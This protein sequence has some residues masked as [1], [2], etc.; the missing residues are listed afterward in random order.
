MVSTN[1]YEC[2]LTQFL[3]A[4][5]NPVDMK[6]SFIERNITKEIKNH[7]E[8]IV[9]GSGDEKMEPIVL[10]GM[11]GSGKSCSA[12][13]CLESLELS[14]FVIEAGK[15][16][17][18]RKSLKKLADD[19]SLDDAF[20]YSDLEK[21][22]KVMSEMLMKS[23]IVLLIEDVM[24]TE[25]VSL[26]DPFIKKCKCIITTHDKRISNIFESVHSLQVP[27]LT[28]K[29]AKQLFKQSNVRTSETDEELSKLVDALDG[30]PFG[31]KIV[32]S[33]MK[34]RNLSVKGILEYLSQH[35]GVSAEGDSLFIA[36]DQFVEYILSVYSEVSTLLFALQF[37]HS[38]D[39]PIIL[40][41][42]LAAYDKCQSKKEQHSN[43]FNRANT[44]VDTFVSVLRRVSFGDVQGED[45]DRFIT[46][47]KIAQYSISR[48]T[49]DGK[50]RE[51]YLKLLK[52]LSWLF[53][54]DH[55]HTLDHQRCLALL[56]HATE[57]IHHYPMQITSVP[58]DEALVF[59]QVCDQVRHTY[60]VLGYASEE[61]NYAKV[62]KEFF[63]KH[64]LKNRGSDFLRSVMN[65]RANA[66]A[67]FLM[68]Q[69]NTIVNENKQVIAELAGDYIRFKVRSHYDI[70]N[71]RKKL[72]EH[73]IPMGSGGIA[74]GERL[75]CEEITWLKDRN[76][77]IKDEC[78]LAR[79]F[80]YE[81]FMSAM[82]VF[83][84]FAL[85][86]DKNFELFRS[87]VNL[88]ICLAKDRMFHNFPSVRTVGIELI[89][90][91][92][93]RLTELEQGV[94]KAKENLRTSIHNVK[95]F[96]LNDKQHFKYGLYV[97]CPKENIDHQLRCHAVLLEYHKACK[98]QNE[99][100]E[101]AEQLK[102]LF[103]QKF[104]ELK[105]VP[106]SQQVKQLLVK[107]LM[108]KDDFGGAQSIL[109]SCPHHEPS[110]T[111]SKY[112]CEDILLLFKCYEHGKQ[113]EEMKTLWAQVT[114]SIPSDE[115]TAKSIIK[116]IKEIKR[117]NFDNR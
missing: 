7:L 17:H 1:V 105:A 84:Q 101:E 55:G 86:Y 57:I 74:C 45:N 54:K 33:F 53:L 102:S 85:C 10:L 66:T 24:S 67:A 22:I 70:E 87:F 48:K 15:E 91:K 90:I 60:D 111:V 73:D 31:L 28:S 93:L 30:S 43:P 106:H 26:L 81:V 42:A 97:L 13:H 52:C 12:I 49:K 38:K 107:Y 100:S 4:F 63:L 6:D 94:P 19:H 79:V 68:K 18:L 2:P 37:V 69:I 23:D 103:Q 40:F 61:K 5:H 88:S 104:E 116:Q 11:R 20:V 92:T 95:Q 62:M 99:T 34:E 51:I 112:D 109:I 110:K 16:N 76:L 36:L 82:N 46:V 32:I 21:S 14:Y 96:L 50:R 108:E 64:L 117:R 98:E 83:G 44:L 35:K 71:L 56:S 8:N 113:L 65:E 58:I 75:S 77:I 27:G 115:E 72:K 29:E 47:Q 39:I 80:V 114:F 78:L 59:V 25:I 89:G 41:Q 9:S 3:R